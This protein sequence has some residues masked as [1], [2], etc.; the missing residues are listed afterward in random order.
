MYQLLL[1]VL[2]M[3]FLAIKMVLNIVQQIK[4]T[5]KKKKKEIASNCN[6]SLRWVISSF[7]PKS[8]ALETTTSTTLTLSH[9]TSYLKV[10][11]LYLNILDV[12]LFILIDSTCWEMMNQLFLLY[13]LPFFHSFIMAVSDLFNFNICAMMIL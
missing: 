9:V 5:W 2:F 7:C 6:P 8:S 1:R 11:R 13:V 4:R 12:Q 3:L 10:M